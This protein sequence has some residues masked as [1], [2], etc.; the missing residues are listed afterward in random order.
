MP[1]TD[2]HPDLNPNDQVIENLRQAH[3]ELKEELEAAETVEERAYIRGKRAGLLMAMAEMRYMRMPEAHGSRR[4]AAAA[5]GI[6]LNN[7]EDD[8]GFDLGGNTFGG[9]DDA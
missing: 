5:T 1:D 3:N 4:S 2:D 8:D 7:E 9:G 6:Q